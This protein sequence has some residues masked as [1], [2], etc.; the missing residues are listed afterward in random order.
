VYSPFTDEGKRLGEYLRREQPDLAAREG[1]IRALL[2]GDS[3]DAGA[4]DIAGQLESLS[5]LALSWLRVLFS[6]P[7]VQL[8]L[9]G[10]GAN[11]I[12]A[13]MAGDPH[14]KVINTRHSPDGPEAMEVIS[15]R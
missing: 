8:P 9:S 6:S 11:L 2:A 5:G 10:E 4:K 15:G 14:K 7:S 1:A 12:T 13:I 3:P